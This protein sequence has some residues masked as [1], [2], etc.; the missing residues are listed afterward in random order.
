MALRWTTTA[1]TSNVCINK[2][3]KRLCSWFAIN[4][5]NFKEK[6]KGKFCREPLRVSE[7]ITR[8]QKNKIQNVLL[9]ISLC[10][11]VR[12]LQFSPVW[13]ETAT[14]MFRHKVRVHIIIYRVVSNF[15]F[16]LSLKKDRNEILVSHWHCQG[17]AVIICLVFPFLFWRILGA[18]ILFHPNTNHWIYLT[19]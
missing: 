2:Y 14:A 8:L 5:L 15:Y 6:G 4:E 13:L 9:L 18:F 1:Q 12:L 19:L 7:A 17:N 10:Y 3:Y 11:A 16:F